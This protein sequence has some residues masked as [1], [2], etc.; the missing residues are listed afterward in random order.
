[1]ASDVGNDVS[2]WHSL[3]A[4][5]D[6]GLLI[7]RSG[8]ATDGRMQWFNAAGQPEKGGTDALF[9]ALALSPDETRLL[10]AY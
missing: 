7:Y 2:T 9:S 3:F 1:M 6:T 5:S 10:L 4:A 8:G